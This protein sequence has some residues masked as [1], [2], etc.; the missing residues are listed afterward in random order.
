MSTPDIIALDPFRKD[1]FSSS[2]KVEYRPFA[3]AMTSGM[4]CAGLYIFA[5]GGPLTDFLLPGVGITLIFWV[6]LTAGLLICRPHLSTARVLLLLA[7]FLLSSCY[8]L[9]GSK[10][11]K[12]LNLPVLVIICALTLQ[13]FAEHNSN[14][15]LSPYYLWKALTRTVCALFSNWRIPF[16]LIKQQKKSGIRLRYA[17]LGLLISALA[18]AIILPLLCSADDVF[19]A[20]LSSIGKPQAVETATMTAVR[21]LRTLL[22]GMPLFSAMYALSQPAAAVAERKPAACPRTPFLVLLTILCAVYTIF[23]YIQILYLSGVLEGAL[24]AGGYAEYARNGFFQLVAVATIDLLV[25]ALTR[26]LTQSSRLLDILCALLLALTAVMLFSAM[27]RMQLYI[28][29]YGLSTLRLLTLW[30][31]AMIA[32]ALALSFARILYPKLRIFRILA[33]LMIGSWI[34]LNYLNV[35]SLIARYNVTAFKQ[36]RLEQLD[37]EYLCTLSADVIPYVGVDHYITSTGSWKDI[38]WFCWD[39]SLT[40]LQSQK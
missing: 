17:V 24:P 25:F 33:A 18:L 12:I 27:R 1:R 31:M 22:L 2:C 19:S 37:S 35:D 13:H 23:D 29:V 3:L 36:G 11:M 34:A 4:L 6:L 30:A 21:I 8:G 20:A 32:T 7:A 40:R 26:I 14:S 10:A 9:F 15:P 5:Y 16:I 38:P 28:S 39:A